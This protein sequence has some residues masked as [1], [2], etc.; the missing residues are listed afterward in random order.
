M[1][2]I[3]NHIGMIT[4]VTM[5]EVDLLLPCLECHQMICRGMIVFIIISPTVRTLIDAN[6]YKQTI[7][8]VSS[9][10]HDS[11]HQAMP[12]IIHHLLQILERIL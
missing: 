10:R 8:L 11:K 1:R 5:V 12:R 9:I 4:S 6:E 3:S 7:S 2:F